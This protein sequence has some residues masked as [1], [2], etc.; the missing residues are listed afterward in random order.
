MQK[1][2]FYPGHPYI[3]F[4]YIDSISGGGGG[5]WGCG[6]LVFLWLDW[7]FIF[8]FYIWENG[9]H[10]HHYHL[11]AI[12]LFHYYSISAILAF[13]FDIETYTTGPNFFWFMYDNGSGA[14]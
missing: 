10:H 8:I 5:G 1:L 6:W 7:R 9:P 3:H 13:I 4:R 12:L 11:S 2:T 14:T